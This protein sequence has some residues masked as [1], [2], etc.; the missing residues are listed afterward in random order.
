[1]T[2]I[3]TISLL[4]IF[5]LRIT[6]YLST[7]VGQ[8]IFW[9][10]FQRSRTVVTHLTADTQ[11]LLHAEFVHL[12]MIYLRLKL[13]TVIILKKSYISFSRY[14]VLL[15]EKKT[16]EVTYFLRRTVIHHSSES[17]IKC[18]NVAPH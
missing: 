7:G 9:T 15:S 13:L 14:F 3:V 18:G 6:Y 16:T 12:L 1:V 2:K 10:S 4:I 8:L 17:Y 5:F 11:T